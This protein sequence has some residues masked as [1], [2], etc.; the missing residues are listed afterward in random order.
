MIRASRADSG[1]DSSVL[2]DIGEEREKEEDLLVIAKRQAPLPL[3]YG[4]LLKGTCFIFVPV[5]LRQDA[6][7]PGC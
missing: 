1:E 4:K 3:A 6:R 7:H 5:E 2:I